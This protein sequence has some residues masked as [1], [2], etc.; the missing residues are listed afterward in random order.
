M[1]F[2]SAKSEEKNG[3]RRSEE[4][5]G[6]AGKARRRGD[7]E[8]DL[9]F[10]ISEV[11]GAAWACGR[12]GLLVP[13]WFFFASFAPSLTVFGL[14]SLVIVKDR[15]EEWSAKERR[16][17]REGRKGKKAGRQGSRFEISEGRGAAWAC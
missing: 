11:R 17:R 5:E 10:E 13:S 14:L 12:G 1:C 7:R 4:S 16:E 9:R 15:R 6:K 3:Q 2:F 8:A